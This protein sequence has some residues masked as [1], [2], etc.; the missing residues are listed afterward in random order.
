MSLVFE[1][2]VNYAIDKDWHSALT[3]SVP[4]RKAYQKNIPQ[5]SSGSE[6][7]ET[8]NCTIPEV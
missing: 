2:L 3:K 4:V 8:D 1:I 7:K 6:E 5:H